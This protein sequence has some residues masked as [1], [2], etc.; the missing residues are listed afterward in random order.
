MSGGSD[1]VRAAVVEVPTPSH[2]V[3]VALESSERTE[4]RRCGTRARSNVEGRFSRSPRQR[5][6]L[7]PG[8]GARDG[9]SAFLSSACP[10]CTGTIAGGHHFAR[11][12]IRGRPAV[13]F[14]AREWAVS[15]FSS[16]ST[17]VAVQRVR[18][19]HQDVQQRQGYYSSDPQSLQ[20]VERRI[21]QV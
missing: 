4:E 19:T 5:V 12:G 3:A 20:T 11:L 2:A 17:S 15:S 8:P 7:S 13:K 18:S 9:A 6:A 14:A 21:D 16:L 1:L 10:A